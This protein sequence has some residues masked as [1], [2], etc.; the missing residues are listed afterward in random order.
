MARFGCL[1]RF[2]R[3]NPTYVTFRHLPTPAAFQLTPTQIQRHRD[4][5][6]KVN[7]PHQ[8]VNRTV[9]QSRTATVAAGLAAYLST[10]SP[11]P[12]FADAVS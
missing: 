8:K 7:E 3:A 1:I 5:G 6:G 12:Y 4:D 9:F 11:R 2:L 10:D